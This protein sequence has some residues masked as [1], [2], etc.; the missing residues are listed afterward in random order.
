[1][2]VAIHGVMRFSKTWLASLLCA[3]PAAAQPDAEVSVITGYALP[4]K[5]LNYNL[6][7]GV[8][9]GVVLGPLYVGAMVAVHQGDDK[10]ITYGPDTLD[11]GGKQDYASL[12]VFA[13]A[14][15][16]YQLQ[17]PL[18]ARRSTLAPFVSAGL[19]AIPMGSSGVYGDSSI[20]NSYLVVGGGV[21][22]SV[23]LN[24]RYAVGLHV[25][26]YDTGDTSFDFGDLSQNTHQH[27]FSTS[28]FYAAAYLESTL[29]F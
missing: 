3:A 23:D 26:V 10:H 2:P 17:I 22:Y 21:S 20:T 5:G 1:M 13:T 24:A 14:D 11:N 16:A 18:G 9:G 4:I 6:G 12:A 15:V 25:R 8:R 29:R 27:G 28:I 7:V 19:L